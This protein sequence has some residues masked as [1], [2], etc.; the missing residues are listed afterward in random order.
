MGKIRNGLSYTH[1]YRIHFVFCRLAVKYSVLMARELQWLDKFDKVMGSHTDVDRMVAIINSPAAVFNGLSVGV[2]AARLLI[3]LGKFFKHTFIPT[4]AEKLL[5]MSE[6]A[7]HEFIKRRCDIANDLVWT[8]VNGLSNYAYYFKLSGPVAAWLTAGFL[9]F[10][11]SLL[12]YRLHLAE[13]EYELKRAQYEGERDLWM[14]KLGQASNLE[15]TNRINR[16]IVMLNEQLK[17]LELSRLTTR[18]TYLFNVAAAGILMGGFSASLLL[19]TPVAVAVC[20]LICTLAVAMYLSANVY[21]K[22]KEK[23]LVLAQCEREEKFVMLNGLQVTQRSPSMLLA[24]RE[25]KEA[26]NDFILTMIKNTMMPMLVVATFAVCWQAAL[27]F[28][29]LYLSYEMFGGYFKK[30][31]TRPLPLMISQSEI[32]VLEGE[33]ESLNTK[34]ITAN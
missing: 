2:P 11:M 3:D 26:R 31:D 19:A 4:D 18:Y 9:I 12:T 33:Q 17:Q 22:Y 30:P 10:D 25:A 29:A 34:G 14:R 16:H 13:Q 7:Y 20:Y 8:T 5:T 23:S 21:G 24:L 15:E 1:I 32:D 6:R 28:T 27:V